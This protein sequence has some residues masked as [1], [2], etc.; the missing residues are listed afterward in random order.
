M[1]RKHGDETACEQPHARDQEQGPCGP[2]ERDVQQIQR[3]ERPEVEV[4]FSLGLGI[5]GAPAHEPVGQL[6]RI[7]RLPPTSAATCASYASWAGGER[8]E[9]WENSAYL[10]PRS[11]SF[12]PSAL[13]CS[14]RKR[15]GSSEIVV[16]AEGNQFGVIVSFQPIDT[17]AFINLN[18]A[19]HLRTA[20]VR[21]HAT[22]VQRCVGRPQP[23][24][25][26]PKIRLPHDHYIVEDNQCAPS[27]R[28]STSLTCRL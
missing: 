19:N 12:S 2:V 10:S 17:V 27:M 13:K 6:G 26:D 9:G 14:L 21:R 1:R 4:E 11:N 22:A 7:A 3:L 15:R 5:V 28:S 20:L 24:Q 18:R 8:A 16:G 25:F 23:C